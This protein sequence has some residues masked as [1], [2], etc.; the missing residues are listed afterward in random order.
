MDFL[1][2][3]RLVSFAAYILSLK[4]YAI[5]TFVISDIFNSN[6]K[7]SI[8]KQER[9]KNL[10]N[11]NTLI[12]ILF[13]SD[14]FAK[15]WIIH[16]SEWNLMSSLVFTHLSKSIANRLLDKTYPISSV[17]FSSFRFLF[18]LDSVFFSLFISSEIMHRHTHSH[19]HR[20][21]S[22]SLPFVIIYKTAERIRDRKI[23]KK[24]KMELYVEFR[25]LYAFAV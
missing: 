6:N 11:V 9:K 10:A 19:T 17:R 22:H 14:R 20:H 15:F 3:S 1:C 8:K 5:S 4:L 7:T 23:E 13:F 18:L 25:Y 12:G 21:H 16:H 2:V 24:E